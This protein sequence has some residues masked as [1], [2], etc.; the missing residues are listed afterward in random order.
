M[1]KTMGLKSFF[2]GIWQKWK[3]I[4]ELIGYYNTKL[5]LGLMFYT[6]FTLYGLVAKLMRKDFLDVKMRS[7]VESYWKEK[8]KEEEDYYKQY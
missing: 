6:L 4:G 3:K 1:S 7:D 2:K 5:L 8:E